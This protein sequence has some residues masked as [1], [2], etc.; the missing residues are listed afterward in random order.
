[1]SCHH[2]VQWVD[3]IL[4]MYEHFSSIFSGHMT[5]EAINVIISCCCIAR[6]RKKGEEKIE[7][8]E[9]RHYMYMHAVY[10]IFAY[11]YL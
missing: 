5:N 9:Q 3:G 7:D 6:R 8:D 10:I 1:M 4:M 2:P 11:I